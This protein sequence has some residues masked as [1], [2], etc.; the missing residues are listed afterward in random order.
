MQRLTGAILLGLAVGVCPPGGAESLDEEQAVLL[1]DDFSGLEPG[2]FSSDVVGAHAEYHYLK[3]LAPKGN[4]HVTCFKSEQSQRAWRVI[5]EDGVWM[6]EEVFPRDKKLLHVHHMIVAGEPLWRDYT[7]RVRFSPQSDDEQSGLVFRYRN[8]RCYYFFGVKGRTAVLKTVRHATAL[9]KPYE[10]ILAEDDYAWE[11][12]K[13]VTA[14]VRVRGSRI[15]AELSGGPLLEAVDETFPDGKIGLICDVPT[16]YSDVRVTTSP[17]EKRRAEAA[18]ARRAA[19]ESR[20]QAANPRPVV[21]KKAYTGGFGVGRNVRFGDLDG[22]GRIDVLIGQ[23]KHHGPNNNNSELGS[24]TAM[25]FDGK[26]LWSNGEKD[27]YNNTHLKNDVAFQVHDIDG[28]GK[29]EA[30]YCRGMEL[31]VAEGASGKI[32]YKIDTPVAPEGTRKGYNKFGRILGDSILFCDVRGTGRDADLVLKSR[33]QFFWVYDDRLNLLWKGECNTGHY[34][35]PYDVD[36]DGK[37]EI[38]MGYTLFDD[39]GKQLWTLDGQLRDHA[40]GV[41]IV[42]FKPGSAARYFCAA[43]DEGMFHADLDGKILKRHFIGHVQNPAVADFRADLPGLEAVSIN[44]WG[45]QGIIHFFDAEGEI[46]H[47]FEPCAHGSMCLPINW[48]GR[49]EEYFVLSPNVGEGGLFDGRGRKVVDFP[50]DGHPESCYAV[51]D[52]TG[53]C[54]DEIVVWDP[55]EM[56]VYTQ[57]DNP[58]PGRLYRPTRNPLYNYS[59]YQ[60][61]VSLPGWSE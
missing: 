24:L 16:R 33:Y 61:T 38:L 44:F 39:D 3:A 27:A 31:V 15:Q 56:W 59:N 17:G 54:R 40:D 50:A 7:V 55:Y 57:D 58:K 47:D 29:N 51:L 34:P 18:V 45:N 32:K 28:D 36:G 41:A 25:R 12:G 23:M 49:P 42:E 26:V 5:R 52:V 10:R 43:S 14:T 35:Y 6:M 11:P 53:D 37:D 4:W 46:I 8:D 1:T 13:F 60:A 19:E 9:H 20:L 22:D 2:M 48:T 30:V 21:W